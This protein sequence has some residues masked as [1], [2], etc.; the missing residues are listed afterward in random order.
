MSDPVSGA[1][2]LET[3]MDDARAVMDAVGSRRAG[4][5]RGPRAQ[6]RRRGYPTHIGRS[7]QSSDSGVT[8][9]GVFGAYPLLIAPL[10]GARNLSSSDKSRGADGPVTRGRKPT[11]CR[12]RFCRDAGFFAPSHC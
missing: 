3:R 9:A 8:K 6:N 11:W 1:P 10:R 5:R 2:M 12:R 4:A 7:M